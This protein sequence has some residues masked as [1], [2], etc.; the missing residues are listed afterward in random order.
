MY[1]DKWS[2]AQNPQRDCR[3]VVLNRKVSLAQSGGQPNALGHIESQQA[4]IGH[5]PTFGFWTKALE[6]TENSGATGSSTYEK[7]FIRL[8]S[9]DEIAS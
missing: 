1:L 7:R 3:T 6:R 4:A 9:Q 8:L 2:T 5:K